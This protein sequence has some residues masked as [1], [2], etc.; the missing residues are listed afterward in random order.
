MMLKKVLVE[1]M[2]LKN[3]NYDYVHITKKINQ[4]KIKR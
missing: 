2:I 3:K 4:H 1:K